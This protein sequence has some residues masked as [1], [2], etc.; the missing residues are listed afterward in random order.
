MILP[1]TSEAPASPGATTLRPEH[2]DLA[3][4]LH[5]DDDFREHIRMLSGR[6]T[7]L[8]NTRGLTGIQ[9]QTKQQDILLSIWRDCGRNSSLLMP[10]F[11]PRFPK[12]KAMSMMDRPFNMILLFMLVYHSTVLRGSRQIGKEQPYSAGILTPKG[13]TTMGE[14]KIG[15]QVI[16][17]D[18]RP[19]RVKAIHEQGVKDVY[20][21]LFT[22]GSKTRCGLE[23]N[24]LV[25]R[26]G[27]KNWKVETLEQIVTRSGYA[28]TSDL[29]VRIPL[30]DPVQF[31]SNKHALTPY[32]VGA[33]LGDGGL[34]QKGVRFTSNDPEILAELVRDNPITLAPVMHN[35]EIVPDNFRVSS[36]RIG[37]RA[38]LQTELKSLGMFGQGSLTKR[39]PESYLLD[40]VK[41]RWELLRG[42]MDT[43]GSIYGKCQVEFY[44]SSEGL[45]LDVAALVE[46]LGGSAEIKTKGAVYLGACGNQLKGAPAWRVKI[47]QLPENPFRLKRKADKFYQIKYARKRVLEAVKLVG[48]EPSRCLEVDSP[49]HTYLTDH[50]IV[51]HNTTS[52]GTRQ[53]LNAHLC[54]D[55]SSL[56]VAPHMNPLETYG[57]KFKDID[58]AFNAPEISGK[59][60]QNI[61]YREYPN[62]SKIEMLRI[63][64]SATPSRGK[65]CDEVI[66]DEAQLFDPG[67]ETEVL[68]VM[69]DSRK[70]MVFY[71]GTSTTIE[72]LLETRY[73]EGTQGVWHILKDD[74]STLNCGDPE[75]VIEHIG[76]Y[77]LTD[78][79]TGNQLNP[80]RGYYH[81]ENPAAFAD[82]ILSIHVPQ[83]INPDIANDKLEWNGLYK[84]LLR[85]K[86]KFIQEKLG[87]PLAE[88]NREVSEQDL[89]RICVLPY[90]PDERKRLCRE[91]YYR[92]IISGFDWGG[93]DYNAMTKS[94]ISNTFHTIIGVA[95]DDKIHLLHARPHGGMDYKTIMNLIVTDHHAYCA[96][97]MASDFGG[98]Q[99]YHSLLRSHPLINAARHIIFDYA[100]PEAPISQPMNGELAN[101]FMLNRTESITALFMG[102]VMAEPLILAPSWDEYGE[103]LLHFMN[104]TRV[105]TE[106]GEG[107]RFR[108]NR[109]GSKSDDFVHSLNM[110]YSLLRL[111]CNQS[112]L[113]EPKSRTIVRDAVFAGNGASFVAGDPWAAALSNYASGTDRFD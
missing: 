37:R 100:G 36:A 45:A 75:Q 104:M 81:F 62:R 22:D 49:D 27:C 23:H 76:P 21:I 63:Q 88:A 71:A 5:E 4:R 40:S 66:F 102:I 103:Y 12:N 69:N 38:F 89:K 25:K 107:R 39:I 41:N 26:S 18:G 53:R 99:Q 105:L 92:I 73:Q 72:T 30:A 6:L 33:L 13:W 59:W 61:Y 65:T 29:A 60:K 9:Y 20:E 7:D 51:T 96:G 85:D 44:S 31:P 112:L 91:G 80:L 86:K 74:G 68:E 84:T 87:I 14:L 34:T 93:S 109:H 57:R 98:G 15:S 106:K 24:W 108:Y 77:F 82:R 52:I 3:R 46:S 35:G 70:K 94:K 1:V 83:I 42:L 48:Q 64:S 101:S 78:P 50:C 10:C 2:F 16:G 95:P 28:P 58:R 47:T 11:F 97:A 90:G 113:A 17:R 19:C 8:D 43:D 32:L 67:L 110:A 111:A 55:F 54:G 56:Y 79:V